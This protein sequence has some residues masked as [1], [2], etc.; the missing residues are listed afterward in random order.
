MQELCQCLFWPDNPAQWIRLIRLY[1]IETFFLWGESAFSVLWKKSQ[2]GTFQNEKSQNEKSQ[3]DTS[4]NE[5]CN[6]RARSRNETW[7]DHC[8]VRHIRKTYGTHKILRMRRQK[9][10][11]IKMRPV[12]QNETVKMIRQKVRQ[13]KSLTV[14]MIRQKVRRIRFEL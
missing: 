5:T 8:I 9:V 14:K 11:R 4:Q 6:F 3:N 13:P 2:N 12:Y 1:H 10:R 7:H